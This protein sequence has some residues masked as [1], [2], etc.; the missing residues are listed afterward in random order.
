MAERLRISVCNLQSGICTT[1]GYWQYVT[2]AWK[3]LLPHGDAPIRKAAA[4]LRS[5][6]VDL[7]LLSEADARSFRTYG[8][9][10]VDMIARETPLTQTAFFPTITSASRN[11]GNA[12]CARFPVRPVENW[13]LPGAG[14]PRYLSEA[15]ICLD[16][17]TI[18]VFAT[19]LSLRQEVRASQ[20]R[21]IAARV[22]D[23]D[24]PTLLGG[25]FNIADSAELGL[26]DECGLQSVPLRPTF[27]SWRPSHVL[28]HLFVSDH[29]E[30]TGSRTFDQ[31]R[32]SDHLP[33]LIDVTLH[34]H[35][36]SAS[37][38]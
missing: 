15:E 17:T 7:A 13:P 8:V 28:D 34:P 11:Q 10:H 16:S 2:T 29:F 25:D 36:D 19:H 33:L 31:F 6:S 4:F 5:E 20:L 26:L 30:V 12:I 23:R 38:S 1:E 37:D 27:P 32:F 35:R 3:Y 24:G 18:R 21:S 9:D 14:E 22:E